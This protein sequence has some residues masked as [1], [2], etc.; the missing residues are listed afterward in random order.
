M[1][2][3]LI[4]AFQDTRRISTTMLGSLSRQLAH[5]SLVFGEGF[6]ADHRALDRAGVLIVE[7]NTTLASA[8]AHAS[9]RTAVLNF[10]NPVTPGGGAAWG[11]M[12]QEE[13]L[14]RSSNLYEG[15]IAQEPQEEFYQYHS[16]KGSALASDRLIY[17]RDVTVFK[18]DERIPRMLD[19][20]EWFSVD[21]ITCAAPCFD[22]HSQME[23]QALADL[24]DS[25]IRNILEAA[26][27]NDVRV[28]ILGAFGCGAFRNPPELVAGSFYRLLVEEGYQYC[29]DKVVFAIRADG[30]A[31]RN[32]L[33][34][35]RQILVP[36]ETRAAAWAESEEAIWQDLANAVTPET[37]VPE[38]TPEEIPEPEAIPEPEQ[39]SIPVAAPAFA[40]EPE[41][42]PEAMP[43]LME[44]AAPEELP[45]PEKAS[46]DLWRE[47]NP[48]YGK[49]FSVLGDSI[50][51]M[52]GAIPEGYMCFYQGDMLEAS[53]VRTSAHTWWSQV[54][55]FLGGELLVNDSWSGC[56]VTAV[57]EG[58]LFP[59]GCSPRRTSRLHKEEIQPDVIMVYMGFNDWAAG[60]RVEGG[61]LNHGSFCFA[62]REML[63]QLQ[64]N[65]PNAEIWCFTLPRTEM[66]SQ[67]Q[68][69]FP[70]AF[71]GTHIRM[72]N[73]WIRRL[74]G[75]MGCKLVDLEAMAFAYDTV[76]G[77]HPTALG[78]ETLA[79]RVLR[80]VAGD[81][82]E[83]YLLCPE[84]SHSFR[85]DR[86]T[87]VTVHTCRICGTRRIHENAPERPAQEKTA[88]KKEK[89][90]FRLF[91]KKG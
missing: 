77:T 53:G 8:R 47:Q 64:E 5:S 6:G 71:A 24:F 67:P 40:E 35:F 57:S 37:T 9:G 29:F 41:E 16:G 65:Y 48:Y 69:R 78:M 75:G 70:E 23:P 22:N 45:V 28:L 10:A 26:I 32:N 4:A 20:S 79:N 81:E 60:V 74:A 90:K 43:M 73:D 18:N 52:E 63:E 87:D 7:E 44:E 42:S 31:E 39:R 68:F 21:V 27:Q 54:I 38:E 15:L 11:A 33:E 2:E 50:S 14:C 19:M 91:G 56:R 62:Y 46:V 86:Y 25:R 89:R 76:D 55:S 3:Q 36:T 1:T 58:D 51:T 66:V 34:V 85:E 59:S 13:C 80:S 12:A 82:A 61:E 83:S 49:R 17:S 72:Y 30:D 88:G 84:D